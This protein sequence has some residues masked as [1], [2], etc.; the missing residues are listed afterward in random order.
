MSGVKWLISWRL[1]NAGAA[2]DVGAECRSRIATC[3][4]AARGSSPLCATIVPGEGVIAGER[5]MRPFEIRRA[6]RLSPT[7]DGG[8]A[9][10]DD[11][12][13]LRS[14]ALLPRRRHQGGAARGRHLA[15]RRRAA[16]R[17]RRA[18]RHGQIQPHPRDRF[19]QPRRGGR[20]RRHQSRDHARGRACRLLLRARS[21]LADRLHHRRQ[22][23]GEFR[24]RALPEIRHDHQQ[25]ARL[26]DGADERRGACASAASISTPAATICS[27]S[28]PARKACSASSPKSPCASCSKPETRARAAD[29]L[30]RRRKTPA[31]A[32]AAS[33]APAS[34]PA[35]WR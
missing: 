17:G 25:R 7:A 20:A 13:G 22:C 15:V 18:A 27:A 16:A 23:R 4:R 6:H 9:A 31:N 32:S 30:S 12:A 1:I 2:D 28:S 26:R 19:R 33:S 3:W 11:R 29:R 24:R 10:G 8:G 5:E 35:A 14:A 34:F 21:V